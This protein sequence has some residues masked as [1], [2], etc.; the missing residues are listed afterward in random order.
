MLLGSKSV[1]STLCQTN[2]FDL[3]FECEL[4]ET[5][6]RKQLNGFCNCKQF[7]GT[8]DMNF[9]HNNS[10]NNCKKM[11]KKSPIHTVCYQHNY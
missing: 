9:T 1:R 4:I 8:Q 11:E 5:I 10:E 2:Q 7:I 3:A 6:E